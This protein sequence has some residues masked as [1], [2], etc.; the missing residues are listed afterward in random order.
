[1]RTAPARARSPDR[2][3]RRPFRPE[4]RQV[5]LAVGDLT[6]D[7]VRRLLSVGGHLDRDLA[8]RPSARAH[9]PITRRWSGTHC[10]L[11]A[12]STRSRSPAS[13]TRRCRRTRSARQSERVLAGLVEHRRRVVDADH[14]GDAELLGGRA[15]SVPL[16]RIR[17]RRPDRSDPARS[18]PAG[19][20]TPGHVLRR[21]V[22]TAR[23]PSQAMT[24]IVL[25]SKRA[26]STLRGAVAVADG[27][28]SDNQTRSPRRRGRGRRDGDCNTHS[29]RSQRRTISSEIRAQL[30]EAIRTGELQ[31]GSP[32][33]AERQLC[34]QFGV[35]RTSVREAIQGS[36]GVGLSR[37]PRQ[38]ARGRRAHARDPAER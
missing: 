31:P 29:H 21:I 14:L 32:V 19:R 34:E 4:H 26:V 37:T 28:W 13:S 20:G 8:S 6:G 18:A 25:V 30:L 2:I 12:A 15:R 7:H 5:R 11:A 1:M 33:P 36:D 16:A 17:G 9:R 23:D 22:G 3:G 10:R 38:P 27:I 35:A 24:C